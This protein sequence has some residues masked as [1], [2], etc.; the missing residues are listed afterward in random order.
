[1]PI[2]VAGTQIVFNDATVQTTAPTT[3]SLVTTAGV[4]NATAG[5]SVG[6]VGTYALMGDTN[7]TNN[8]PGSTKAGSQLRYAGINSFGG[9]GGGQTSL[10]AL[11]YTST[12]PA[13]TWRCMGYSVVGTTEIGSYYG[14]TLW[15]RIS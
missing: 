14:G 4:L 7:G 1:M 15:L 11:G 2:T 13:G 8:I 6:A 5:A 10:L 12:T 3:A 9:W